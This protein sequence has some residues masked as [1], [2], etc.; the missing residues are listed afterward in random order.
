MP[1]SDPAAV[2]PRTSCCQHLS[3]CAQHNAPAEPAG[4]CDCGKGGPP[5]RGAPPDWALS[6]AIN[7]ANEHYDGG[8][9]FTLARLLASV[10]EG[11]LREA[12]AKCDEVSIDKWHLYKGYPPYVGNEEG[13]ADPVVDGECGGATQCRDAI[14]SLLHTPPS[15]GAG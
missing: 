4:P 11:A 14:L 9:A 2:P 3:D 6:M 15:G 7:H 8:N 1:P 13:R 10:R 12:A 5:C